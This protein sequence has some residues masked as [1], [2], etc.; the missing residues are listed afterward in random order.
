MKE[1]RREMKETKIDRNNSKIERLAD[2]ESEENARKY[3]L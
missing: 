3:S 2:K 1:G